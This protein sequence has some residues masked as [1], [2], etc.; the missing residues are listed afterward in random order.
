MGL[1]TRQRRE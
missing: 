1:E